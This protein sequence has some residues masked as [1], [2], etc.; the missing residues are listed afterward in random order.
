MRSHA[1]AAVV[2]LG[3]FN[4]VYAAAADGPSED[5]QSRHNADHG[6]QTGQPDSDTTDGGLP[7]DSGRGQG[8][9]STRTAPLRI[10]SAPAAPTGRIHSSGQQDSSGGVNADLMRLLGQPPTTWIQQTKQDVRALDT[11]DQQLAAG[12]AL[13]IRSRKAAVSFGTSAAANQLLTGARRKRAGRISANLVLGSEAKLRASTD[14]GSL[15]GG[16]A[17]SQGVVVQRRTPVTTDPRS[18]GSRIGKLAASGSYWV[19]ARQDLD[20]LLSKIDSRFID[21]MIVIKGPYAARLG[22]GFDFVDIELLKAPRYAN[23]FESHGATS[24]E[25]KTNGEQWYGRQSL[26]GGGKDWGYHIGYGHR[27]GSDYDTG[28]NADGSEFQPKS[29]PT[30]YK[31]RDLEVAVGYDPTDDSHLDFTY[32][33]LDQTDVEFPGLVFDVNYLVTD[34]YELV[35][36]EKNLGW[37]DHFEAE[38]WYNRTEFEGDTLRSGKNRQVPT[39]RGGAF[40]VLGGGFAIT[41]VDGTSTGFRST[42]TWG[43]EGS[44]QLSMGTDLIYLNQELNDRE[45]AFSNN[46]P[47]PESYSADVGLFVEHNLTVN[48][49]LS[50]ASGVRIDMVNANS[51]VDL[52]SFFGL[53]DRA[54]L[55]GLN[56]S[57]DLWSAF[58][59][60]EYDLDDQWTAT[61][62][63]AFAQRAPSLTELYAE[64]PFIG[65]I[66][67]GLSYVVGDPELKREYRRQIDVGLRADYG[68]TRFSANGFYA[69]INDYIVFENIGFELFVPGQ[70]LAGLSYGNTDLATLSGFEL[71]AEDD[72]T[73]WLTAFGR[74]SFVEGRDHSRSEPTRGGT[75]VNG[76]TSL[77][78][79]L[80]FGVEEEP[81]PGIPP[82]EARVGMRLHEPGDQFSWGVEFEARIV[83]NQDRVAVSLKEQETPGFTVFNLRSY[84]RAQENLLLIAGVENFTDK[85][86]R[87]HLDYRTGRGVFQPGINFYFSAEMTW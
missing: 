68:Q 59:T 66:Q 79:G 77:P 40:P 61:A 50:F 12:A 43:D 72:M 30:S 45:P 29:L 48:D 85:F 69:W 28:G 11:Q 57:F 75:I 84:W 47:I 70:D 34:A 13:S 15:L 1:L 17:S 18:R 52:P 24:L 86:Y 87:E 78:R 7:T 37:A 49:R 19:P 46:F 83:D 81:L 35:Y 42:A 82:L 51:T 16:S 8:G 55:A 39:L 14:A 26:W 2:L 33:R 73:P 63:V 5:T 27:T 74:M 41:D 60:A 4:G 76:T 67:P 44:S 10:A 56:Q 9:E 65:S 31:S 22:P 71:S 25:Y 36:E 64:S 58:G 6:A 32:M 21:D 3:V 80:V 62:G 23:G 20:T 38:G 54:G 53:I